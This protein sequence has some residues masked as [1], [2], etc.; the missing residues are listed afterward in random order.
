M[1]GSGAT[2]TSRGLSALLADRAKKQTCEPRTAQELQEA[3]LRLLNCHQNLSE[4]LL[5]VGSSECDKPFYSRGSCTGGREYSAPESFVVP[6]LQE[7]ASMLGV[8]L[9]VLSARTAAANIEKISAES[10]KA[11]LLN[12]EQRDPLILEL[13]WRLH[14][15]G[16]LSLEELLE[17]HPDTSALED[18]LCGSLRLLCHQA[19]DPSVDTETLQ[20]ILTGKLLHAK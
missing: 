11:V 2:A 13:A 18:W 3:A 9:G 19:E 20:G 12:A 5:E 4:L 17:N 7:E 14:R 10:G 16:I 8:P 15:G 6:A 1:E